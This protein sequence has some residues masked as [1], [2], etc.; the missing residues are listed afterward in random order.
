M[1]NVPE[2]KIALLFFSFIWAVSAI[3]AQ[4]VISSQGESYS[5]PN[6]KVDFTIGEVVIA[7]VSDGTTT[8]TQGFHQTNW[9]FSGVKDFSPEMEITVFPNPASDLLQIQTAEFKE[10]HYELYDEAGRLVAQ[11]ELLEETTSVQVAELAT[12]Q[13]SLVLS[14]NQQPLKIFKLIKSL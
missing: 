9:K 2:M 5:G 14:K 4:E 10:V 7:T 13:Y 3:N 8:L 11:N 6:A 12:G 1:I